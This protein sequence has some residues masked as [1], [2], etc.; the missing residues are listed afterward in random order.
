MSIQ[1]IRE[2]IELCADHPI[3]TFV[4]LCVLGAIG[5]WSI[6]FARALRSGK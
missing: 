6:K 2:V 3:A 1:T 5:D 4:A